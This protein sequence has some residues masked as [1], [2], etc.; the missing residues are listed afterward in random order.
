MNLLHIW[1]ERPEIQGSLVTVRFELEDDNGK[2]KR[3]WYR[4][5]AAQREAI[6]DQCDSFVL[7]ALFY[8]MHT[9][10]DLYVHGAVSP[11]LLRNLE[12]YQAIWRSWLPQEYQ[13]IEIRAEVEQEPA[14]A[15]G[16]AAIMAFSGGLD[17]AF[18]ARRHRSGQAGRQ[19]ENIQAGMILHGFD[20]PLKSQAAFDHAHDRARK[21]LD[22]LG[23][24]TIPLATNLRSLGGE[25]ANT[26][27]TV[28]ASCLSLLQKRFQ[29]GLIAN[30]EP[31]QNLIYPWALVF[32]STSLTDPYLSSQTFSILHD[33][34]NF[35]RFD[36]TMLVAD[37]PEALRYLRVCI[38]R[39]PDRRVRNCCRC[40]KCISNIL[41]FR[42]LGLGLPPCFEQD[43]RNRQILLMK[44]SYPRD[45]Y[46]QDEVA[47]KSYYY[48]EILKLARRRE[49][50]QTWITALR[51]AIAAN[52]LLATARRFI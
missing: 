48:G 28:L 9:P 50:R 46:Y 49:L 31:N 26:H 41:T 8:A 45:F 10:A 14:P 42:A 19:Q 3:L 29:A 27:A 30:S 51:L 43:V 34:A 37:W 39:D 52:R 20:I 33:G 11:S 2:R 32:G 21:M 1:P 13:R 7:A 47:A 18:T 17:S 35:N 12:E 15:C 4:L 16:D 25:F 22:S 5:P 36:K 24:E 44:F 6:S 40:E 38:G 23:M